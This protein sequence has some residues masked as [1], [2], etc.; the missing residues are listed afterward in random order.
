[1]NM[2]YAEL[3]AALAATRDAV[4]SRVDQGLRRTVLTLGALLIATGAN[5]VLLVW[6]FS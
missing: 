5:V 1:M 2:T 4:S 3:S 6:K